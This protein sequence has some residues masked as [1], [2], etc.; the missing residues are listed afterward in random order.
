MES[1]TDAMGAWVNASIGIVEAS[2]TLLYI[3]IDFLALQDVPWHRYFL[4]CGIPCVILPF[5]VIMSYESPRWLYAKG[6]VEKAKEILREISGVEKVDILDV[7]ST[8]EEGIPAWRLLLSQSAIKPMFIFMFA[9]ASGNTLY[10]GYINNLKSFDQ[11]GLKTHELLAM[12]IS[13]QIPAY[14]FMGALASYISPILAMVSLWLATAGCCVGY[15]FIPKLYLCLTGFL[16]ASSAYLL[17]FQLVSE[18]S[19]TQLRATIMGL[20]NLC[21]RLCSAST[22]H[23][24]SMSSSTV[25]ILYASLATAEVLLLLWFDTGVLTQVVSVQ[26]VSVEERTVTVEATCPELMIDLP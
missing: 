15:M 11:L 1:A 16:F 13:V 12:I 17:T 26:H 24:D 9:F 7:N 23:F 19:P 20:C 10:Y 25:M 5:V 21:A 8:N 3:G 4:Y 18:E 14:I 6:E 2:L 22:A